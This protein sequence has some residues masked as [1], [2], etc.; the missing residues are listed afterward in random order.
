MGKFV[1]ALLPKQSLQSIMAINVNY[2][3]VKVFNCCYDTYF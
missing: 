3:S 1:N 2:S